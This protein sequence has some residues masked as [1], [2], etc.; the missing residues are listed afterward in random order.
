MKLDKSHFI[1]VNLFI[2]ILALI[3]KA[4]LK[5]QVV[6]LIAKSKLIKKLNFKGN[7]CKMSIRTIHTIGCNQT[8]AT[9]IYPNGYNQKTITACIILPRASL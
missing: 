5:I 6:Y 3:A 4:N 8:V 1:Y 9:N 2:N 7:N